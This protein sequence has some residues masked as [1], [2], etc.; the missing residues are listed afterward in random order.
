MI[1]IDAMG[2]KLKNPI[3]V[4]AGPWT[5]GHKKI[6]EAL[7]SGAAAVV[8]ESIV[9]EPYP[10]V[11]PRYA[12]D[13]NGLQNIRM[14]SG[15]DM[16]GWLEEFRILRENDRF[17]QDGLIIANIM[18]ST[19]SE[20]S[21]VAGKFEKAG[22]DALEL[23]LACP[24]GEGQEIIAGDAEKVYNFTKAVVDSVNIPVMV[25]LTQS[26][27]NLSD[28]V[29]A[30][31]R[32]GASGVT[33]IDTIRCILGIDTDTGKPILPT[34]GGY[35]G[36]PIRPI[37]LAMIAGMAQSTELPIFAIGGIENYKHALAEVYS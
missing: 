18:A 9:S 28:V 7:K 30:L 29:D 19:P 14:Y 25:K 20:L 31:K 36:G 8:T 22:A 4:S 11:S 3:I 16:E 17:G 33:G 27:S 37:G 2:L 6:I 34:Y 24:M 32:A 23:G 21:Y 12:F 5:R 26:T 15:L 1:T 13:G 35:S 10:D